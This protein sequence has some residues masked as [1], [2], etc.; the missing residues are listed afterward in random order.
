MRQI[1]NYCFD[2]NITYSNYTKFTSG[3]GLSSGFC[4]QFETPD[5]KRTPAGLLTKSYTEITSNL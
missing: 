2:A 1:Y 3:F 4:S 5:K